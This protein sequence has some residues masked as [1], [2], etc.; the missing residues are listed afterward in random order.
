[1]CATFGE[2]HSVDHIVEPGL[3]DLQQV[4]TSLAAP[5]DRH[6]KIAAELPLAYV[7]NAACL[8]LAPQL[9]LVVR[10]S[11]AAKLRRSAMLSRRVAPLLKGAFG[12]ETALSFEEEL[13][14]LS[15]A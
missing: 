2:P 15:A 6:T 3:Q 5:L 12:R 9:A 13:F 14:T 10:H 4:L 11:P 8:L 1:M 7:V